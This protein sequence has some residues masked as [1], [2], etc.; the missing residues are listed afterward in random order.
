MMQD[1]IDQKWEELVSH[2]KRVLDRED[3]DPDRVTLDQLR[4]IRGIGEKLIEILEG[5]ILP[6]EIGLCPFPAVLEMKV[7]LHEINEEIR[8][9]EKEQL[10][11]KIHELAH[12]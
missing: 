4:E 3:F 10:E 5:P 6:R 7:Q 2:N 9:M 12:C 11:A 1:E 8:R